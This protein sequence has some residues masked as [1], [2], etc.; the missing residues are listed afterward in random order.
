MIFETFT[1]QGTG[2]RFSE[3]PIILL[4]YW[5]KGHS[6]EQSEQLDR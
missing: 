1:K 4:G 5:N 3:C 2:P 6:H